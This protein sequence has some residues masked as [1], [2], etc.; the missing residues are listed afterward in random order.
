MPRSRFKLEL[1]RLERAWRALQPRVNP[2]H[3]PNTMV[4]PA[5]Q[6]GP[7]ASLPVSAAA[8][9][10]VRLPRAY[11]AQADS[12]PVCSVTDWPTGKPEI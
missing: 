7:G 10:A 8:A 9:S 1:E 6:A 2:F 12:E 4:S 3:C 5:S 11:A